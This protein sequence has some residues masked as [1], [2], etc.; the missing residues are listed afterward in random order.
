MG[1]ALSVQNKETIVRNIEGSHTC[2]QLQAG[3]FRCAGQGQGGAGGSRNTLCDRTAADGAGS[4]VHR[5]NAA[6]QG[7][8]VNVGGG[9]AGMMSAYFRIKTVF[10][11]TPYIHL[12]EYSYLSIPVYI[13]L[14]LEIVY[15]TASILY[16]SNLHIKLHFFHMVLPIFCQITSKNVKSKYIKQLQKLRSIPKE[17]ILSKIL[18]L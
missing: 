16:I 5:G 11:N 8:A 9:A 4:T 12:K 14:F 7:A 17:S 15:R 3:D 1:S 2:S 6:I 10:V 18:F 13:I